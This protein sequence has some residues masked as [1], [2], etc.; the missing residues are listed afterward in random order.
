[1][2]IASSL[3]TFSN[4]KTIKLRLIHSDKM[5]TMV[6]MVIMVVMMVVVMVAM[7]VMVMVLLEG[8]M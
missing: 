1:M 2:A 3:W 5:V 4:F 8:M 7:V 6:V